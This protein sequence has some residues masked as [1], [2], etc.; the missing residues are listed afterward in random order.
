M[1]DTLNFIIFQQ[2]QQQVNV[3]RLYFIAKLSQTTTL[4][5]ARITPIQR[6]IDPPHNSRPVR[7]CF[8]SQLRSAAVSLFSQY[9][10]KT[11]VR[12]SRQWLFALT[13]CLFA[14]QLRLLT[15]R[16][17]FNRKCWQAMRRDKDAF[18]VFENPNIFSKYQFPFLTNLKML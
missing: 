8:V 7:I 5:V 3:Q 18:Q 17:N 14:L 11:F 12:F 4:N 10:F 16:F 13:L 6:S 9:K 2:Q 1:V 15:R